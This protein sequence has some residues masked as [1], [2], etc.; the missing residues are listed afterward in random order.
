M[1]TKLLCRVLKPSWTGAATVK[2]RFGGSSNKRELEKELAIQFWLYSQ[3][4]DSRH[5]KR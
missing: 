3:N 1:K 4:T 2:N 5:L